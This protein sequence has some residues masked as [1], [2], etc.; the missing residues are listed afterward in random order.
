MLEYSAFKSVQLPVSKKNHEQITNV[1][2]QLYKDKLQLVKTGNTY[3]KTDLGILWF[4]NT[5][6][7]RRWLILACFICKR[8]FKPFPDL[9]NCC[10]NYMY[11][12]IDIGQ[13]PKFE[14]HDVT[15][16]LAMIYK[17]TLEYSELQLS[18]EHDRLR[19]INP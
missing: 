6:G 8:A 11:N 19:T 4:L 1:I 2:V 16:R 17:R 5:S 7:C 13:V 3:K 10:D 14:L 12:H 18:I 9:V 15:V